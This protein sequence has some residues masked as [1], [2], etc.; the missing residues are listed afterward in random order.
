M[1]IDPPATLGMSLNGPDRTAVLVDRVFC[2]PRAMVR[3]APFFGLLLAAALVSAKPSFSQSN[4][5]CGSMDLPIASVDKP[6]TQY[7]DFC[8]RHPASCVLDGEPTIEW[9]IEIHQRLSDVN[10]RVNEEVELVS[11]MDNLGLEENWDFP[12][13]CRGDC[14]DFVL[15]KREKLVEL[16]FPRAAL[17]IAIGFHEDR[18]FPHAVLLAETDSGTW[19]LDNLHGEVLC[20]DATPY[21]YTRRERPDGMWLRYVRER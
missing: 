8:E 5:R 20:W 14:E 12:K 15:E 17:T 4:P 9:T 18:F 1:R 3:S 10:A 21:R 2:Y 13:D 16:G 11:D 7:S 6:P 19:V